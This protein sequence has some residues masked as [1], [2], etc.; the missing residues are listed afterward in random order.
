LPAALR[1]C[2]TC[3]QNKQHNR[4]G[5]FE[6]V[7]VF[8]FGLKPVMPSWQ[9]NDSKLSHPASSALSSATS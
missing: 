5:N 1:G 4:E 9:S 7:H 3:E 6:S 8:S 2:A